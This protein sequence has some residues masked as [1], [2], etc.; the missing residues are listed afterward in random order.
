MGAD[1]T[2]QFAK[3]AYTSQSLM[4]KT[5]EQSLGLFTSKIIQQDQFSSPGWIHDKH[6]NQSSR[7]HI[8]FLIF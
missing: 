6:F 1:A 4:T 3:W 8:A 7:L 5:F 2:R